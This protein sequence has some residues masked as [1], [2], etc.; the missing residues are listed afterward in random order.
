MDREG[1]E[2]GTLRTIPGQNYFRKENDSK[3]ARALESLVT[4]ES[5]PMEPEPWS[6]IN[7]NATASFADGDKI[8]CR[9][10]SALWLDRRLEYLSAKQTAS[11]GSIEPV[12][13]DDSD[14]TST[15]ALARSVTPSVVG[16]YLEATSRMPVAITQHEHLGLALHSEL[17]QLKPG[18]STLM[19]ISLTM[20]GQIGHACALELQFKAGNK[21]E[22][23]RYVVT[24]FD[25]NICKHQRVPLKDPEEIRLYDMNRFLKPTRSTAK[26]G[27]LVY[28][29][30]WPAHAPG[31]LDTKAAF[32]TPDKGD[33]SPV[34]KRR[35]QLELARGGDQGA[36][37]DLIRDPGITPYQLVQVG[38]QLMADGNVKMYRIFAEAVLQLE[39]IPRWVLQPQLSEDIQFGSLGGWSAVAAAQKCGNTLMIDTHFD[40]VEAAAAQHGLSA[41]DARSALMHPMHRFWIGKSLPGD[42]GRAIPAEE[43][44]QRHEQGL[45]A[46]VKRI[47]S[48]TA[49]TDD[50]KI[51]VFE[52]QNV[53]RDYVK[54]GMVRMPAVALCAVLESGAS[55]ELVGKM[56]SRSFGGLTPAAILKHLTSDGST[57]DPWLQRILDAVGKRELTDDP[58]FAEVMSHYGKLTGDVTAKPDSSTEKPAPTRT[59]S[60]SVPDLVEDSAP[61]TVHM[62]PQVLK[63]EAMPT[64]PQPRGTEMIGKFVVVAGLNTTCVH[65]GL[66]AD[67]HEPGTNGE[68]MICHAQKPIKYLESFRYRYPDRKMEDVIAYSISVRD[69]SVYS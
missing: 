30:A 61:V 25:P 14:F 32:D 23:P 9:H 40:I 55:A 10:M 5:G 47:A 46:Y 3:R 60:A 52:E 20:A 64:A 34:V 33:L 50:D 24:F 6:L 17:L 13:F 59:P 22:K 31:R 18:S 15:E 65:A 28:L 48:S 8:V 54:Q 66:R 63:P 2:T 57:G 67:R 29:Y 35:L 43:V 45:H 41:E 26:D 12:T 39:T 1:N 11:S 56:I 37:E 53:L 36:L 62:P 42:H 4:G 7:L 69:L 68:V 44:R 16:H 58:A 49:L 38:G 19:M 21:D 27:S 51:G